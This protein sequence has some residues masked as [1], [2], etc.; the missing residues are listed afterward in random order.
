M[1]LVL[2]GTGQFLVTPQNNSKRAQYGENYFQILRFLR[3]DT[4]QTAMYRGELNSRL[5]LCQK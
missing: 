1:H 5:V 3:S 4:N 2:K